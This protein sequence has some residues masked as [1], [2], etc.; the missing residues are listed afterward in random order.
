M[1]DQ[2][3]QGLCRRKE[4]GMKKQTHKCSQCEKELKMKEKELINGY[5]Y[6][7]GI[8]ENLGCPFYKRIQHREEL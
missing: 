5:L 2:S 4:V 6:L 7:A 1:D 8:C 3:S